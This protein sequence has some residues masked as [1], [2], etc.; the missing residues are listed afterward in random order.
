[1]SKVC[2][3]TDNSAQF[4]TASFPGHNLVNLLPLHIMINESLYKEG[5][6]I[7]AHDLPP[8]A[9]N[10]FHPVVL[11][12]TIDE[13]RQ[14]YAYLGQRYDEIVV[15]LLS[16]K[17]NSAS[18]SAQEAAE[19]MQGRIKIHVVDSQTMAIGLG[20]LVQVAAKAAEEG[21]PG[22]E[23]VRLLRG[24]LPHVYC[25]LCIPGLTFLQNIGVIGPA[26]A[27]VGEKL[28]LMPLFIM[29]GGQLVAVQ[30]A[31]SARHL[32]DCLHEFVC[33]FGK[34]E[35]IAVMQGVPPYEQEVRAL[36]ERFGVDFADI[37]LSEHT[38][39]ASMGSL[40]GPH[41]LGLFVMESTDPF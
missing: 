35:H 8:S 21:Q 17:L 41:S 28:E 20:L 4:P 40:L 12:P 32:V 14:M 23:I 9:F 29:D 15:L 24:L 37:P 38:I 39:S 27:I 25:M 13:F 1:M 7:K 5:Q 3:L 19:S 22:A 33:E 34:L 10:D 6:G 2:I 11:P 36:R 16:A 30:K 31:R 26:Q 18:T